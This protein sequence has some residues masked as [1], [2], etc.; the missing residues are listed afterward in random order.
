ML[1]SSTFLCDQ[2][3][4][5]AARWQYIRKC[6]VG[7]SAIQLYIVSFYFAIDVYDSGQCLST[8]VVQR[9]NQGTIMEHQRCTL[10]EDLPCDYNCEQTRVVIPPAKQAKTT[11]NAPSSI[12]QPLLQA[13]R[14]V[15]Q[16]AQPTCSCTRIPRRCWCLSDLINEPFG[17]FAF[18]TSAGDIRYHCLFTADSKPVLSKRTEACQARQQQ[19]LGCFA[20]KEEAAL[21]WDAAVREQG[22]GDRECVARLIVNYPNVDCVNTSDRLDGKE[23]SAAVF[24]QAEI[25]YWQGFG[26]PYAPVDYDF[27]LEQLLGAI[28]AAKD[29][30]AHGGDGTETSRNLMQRLFRDDFTVVQQDPHD[31][32]AGNQLCWSFQP[33]AFAVRKI[34]L[35]ARRGGSCVAPLS[36]RGAKTRASAEDTFADKFQCAKC[37][38]SCM[39]YRG[40]LGCLDNDGAHLPRHIFA[41]ELRFMQ[42][43]W[44]VNFQPLV[45][46]AIYRRYAGRSAGIVVYDSSAGWGGRLLGAYLSGVVSTYIACE[47][48]SSTFTGLQKMAAFLKSTNMHKLEHFRTYLNMCGSENFC[49]AHSSVD[50]ALTSPPYF[51]LE[52]YSDEATQAHMRFPLWSDWREQFLKPTLRNTLAALKPH[53]AMLINIANNKMFMNRGVDLE[54]AV[55]DCVKEL[56]GSEGSEYCSCSAELE[57]VLTM[58]KPKWEITTNADST[59]E[60][61][62][63]FRKAMA[64]TQQHPAAIAALS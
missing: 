17:A 63:V 30:D 23:L 45:A 61:V 2:F 58:R 16:P 42:G 56:H 59:G 11:Y 48:C 13:N 27:R 10:H 1:T 55:V 22:A 14:E 41:G 35:P 28:D 54:Q 46:A 24:L 20:T 38:R 19:F 37:V 51:A 21:R 29:D 43:S 36:V 62:F 6:A 32:A 12:M 52:L 47:P 50:V 8:Q 60:P 31:C 5:S 53:G 44:V 25:K 49:P 15:V 4:I 64:P 9:A 39:E 26:F 33:H 57:T 3:C 7:R 40:V 34:K 18:K